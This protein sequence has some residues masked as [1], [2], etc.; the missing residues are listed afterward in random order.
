MK[1]S[2]FYLDEYQ[3]KKVFSVKGGAKVP[4]NGRS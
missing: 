1:S 2:R 4:W 3:F